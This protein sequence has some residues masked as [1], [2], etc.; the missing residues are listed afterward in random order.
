MPYSFLPYFLNKKVNLEI[1]TAHDA[2]IYTHIL[3]QKLFT[4]V[5]PLLTDC[6]D[7]SDTFSFF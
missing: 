3:C 4:E 6:D 7:S 2:D 1:L 5:K